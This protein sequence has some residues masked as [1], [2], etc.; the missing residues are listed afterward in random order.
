MLTWKPWRIERTFVGLSACQF[1]TLGYVTSVTGMLQC[2]ELYIT[3]R[4]CIN[5][6]QTTLTRFN[7]SV[8][9]AK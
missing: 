2:A 9:T 6:T 1:V 8:R 7:D 4:S 3:Y 5:P